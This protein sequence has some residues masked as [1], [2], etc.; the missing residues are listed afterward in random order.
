MKPVKKATMKDVAKACG[1]S[2]MA[3]SMA[4][5]G[6][7]GISQ[8]TRERILKTAKA[9]RYT[10]N[11]IAKSLRVRETRTLGVVTSDSSHL[12]FAKLL[13][14]IGDAADRH[15]YSIIIANTGQSVERER[16]AIRTLITKRIDGL[17]LAAPM[18]VDEAAMGE[19][20]DLDI[21]VA[22]LMRSGRRVVDTVITDN[23][24]GA[25]EMVDYLAASGSRRIHMI[26]LNRESRT[27]RERIRGCRQ[28][29]KDHG[30]TPGEILYSRPFIA[31]G[32]AAM[33]K[34]L[35]RN[36]PM[37]AVFCGCD[38]IAI[39]AMR[40]ILEKGLRIPR[41]IRLCGFDDIDLLEDLRV[42]LTTM[43]QPI[44]GMGREG[45]GLLLDRI[46]DPGRP[47]QKVVMPGELVIRA[48]T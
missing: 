37:D 12:L 4:M 25:Y 19:A 48:S 10:P 26:S 23:Y 40:A 30:L 34:L 38:V 27:G 29:W 6:K 44:H 33:K 42:P 13:T 22:V 43:R 39:G 8:E 46:R 14:A 7:A 24:R 20:E 36:R 1:V 17:L 9:M 47:A 2:S 41:D 45:V 3:V 18:N 32:Y 21:P 16:T 5:S 31:D 35:A 28:A 11:L 15:G